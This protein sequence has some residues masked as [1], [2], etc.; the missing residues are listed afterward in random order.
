MR[1]EPLHL[2]FSALEWGADQ[3]PKYLQL[4]DHIRQAILNGQLRSGEQLPPSRVLAIQLG[5][6]RTTV[7]QAYGHLESEGYLG[8]HT[9]SGTYVS[10]QVPGR[11]ALSGLSLADGPLA[12]DGPLLSERG[13]AAAGFQAGGWPKAQNLRPF[14]PGVPALWDFPFSAWFRLMGRQSRSLGFE[15]FGYGDAA[16]YM[17]LRRALAMYLRQSRGVRCEPEQV[18]IVHGTQQALALSCQLLLDPGDSAWIEDPGYNGAKE[19]MHLMGVRPIPVPLGREGISVEAGMK[20]GPEARL[21]YVTPSHQYPTGVVM[22]L[23]RRLELLEWAA[24]QSAWILEDDYDSE[25]RYSGKPLAALQ[26]IGREGRAVYLGT[27]SKVLFPALRMGYI[28][29][30]PA[31]AEPF[32]RA[33]AFT[34]RGNSILEQATLAA[35]LEEGHLERHLRRMRLLY[36]ERQEA[37]IHWSEK[38]LG[39]RL[40]I[41]P[42]DTGLH[43]VGWL[44]EHSDDRQVAAQLMEAG[45]TASPL[46]GYTQQYRQPPGLVLGYAPYREEQIRDALER[47]AGVLEQLPA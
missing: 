13:R 7:M 24:R 21:A 45:V 16:G 47:M 30:P 8:G 23:G 29:A 6:S 27:F 14:R 4:Y 43:A 25:Y 35:Y 1:T 37:L 12:S 41:F 39:D 11:L 42:S 40:R 9:G 20:A 33:K 46:S 36:K 34:D 32:Q 5:V 3:R 15:A 44:P 26:G 10:E 38:L 17:P 22:S 19:A 31:L 18:I 2:V 28:V